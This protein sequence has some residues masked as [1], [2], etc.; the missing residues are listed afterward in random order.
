MHPPPPEQPVRSLRH[1]NFCIPSSAVMHA[2]YRLLSME[3]TCYYPRHTGGAV[4][5]R[6]LVKTAITAET[7][8]VVF[9]SFSPTRHTCVFLRGATAEPGRNHGGT[10]TVSLRTRRSHW[11][12]TAVWWRSHG[13]HWGRGLRCW[14]QQ[15]GASECHSRA[16]A[17]ALW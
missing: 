8:P 7:S 12:A 1:I 15:C 13:D 14:R 9:H 10:T 5:L 17:V 11:V 4:P 16:S 6:V 2:K 3:I